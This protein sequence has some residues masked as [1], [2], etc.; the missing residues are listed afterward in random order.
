MA[1]SDS[2]HAFAKAVSA[3]LLKLSDGNT[4]ILS[5]MFTGKRI[6]KHRPD[7]QWSIKAYKHQLS[8]A[9]ASCKNQS[10]AAESDMVHIFSL[11]ELVDVNA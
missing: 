1:C 11:C 8:M 2:Q 5:R 10:I 3:G 7:L 6:S 4:V 9:C